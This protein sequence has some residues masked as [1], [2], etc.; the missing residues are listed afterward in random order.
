MRATSGAT[1]TAGPIETCT[2]TL[3]RTSKEAA[4]LKRARG[5]YREMPGLRLTTEQA[6][7]LWD[8]DRETC[9]ALLSGLVAERYLQIDPYGR[10]RRAQSGY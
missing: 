4:L 7:R 2:V 10:Y 9:Q 1:E 5:E 8:V 3:F 6:M